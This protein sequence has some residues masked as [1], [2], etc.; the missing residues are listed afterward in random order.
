MK[1]MITTS[2][3]MMV[4]KQPIRMD[5]LLSSGGRGFEV[6]VLASVKHQS[7]V[8]FNTELCVLIGLKEEPRVLRGVAYLC[9][10]Q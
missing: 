2:R 7:G 9:S 8:C 10:L 6:T 5:V 1:K 4:T 3:R